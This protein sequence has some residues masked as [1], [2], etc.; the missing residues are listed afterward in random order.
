MENALIVW[1]RTGKEHGEDSG[2][3]ANPPEVIAAELRSKAE[4]FRC[5]DALRRR[6]LVPQSKQKPD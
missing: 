4:T 3:R 6:G 2:F 5:R 1:R